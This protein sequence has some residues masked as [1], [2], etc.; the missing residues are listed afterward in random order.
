[1]KPTVI[2][3]SEHQYCFS[4]VNIPIDNRYGRKRLFFYEEKFVLY[5]VFLAR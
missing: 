1:M 4:N 2:G 3:R 5:S